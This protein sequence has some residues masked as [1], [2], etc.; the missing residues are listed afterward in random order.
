MTAILTVEDEFLVSEYLG[1]ILRDKGY[2]VISTGGADEAIEVPE[3]RNDIRL[4]ITDINM[5]GTLD[6]LKLAA[7]V[8]N[9][10]PPIKI[11]LTT[12][13]TPPVRDQMPSG[14][15]FLPKPYSPASVIETVERLL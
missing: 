4:V 14:S 15:L 5:P 9:R 13:K 1:Q 7:A 11:I 12:G 2:S 3:S 6:G 8:K 10:W